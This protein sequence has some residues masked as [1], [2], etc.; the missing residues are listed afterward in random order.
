MRNVLLTV[1]LVCIPAVASAQWSSFNGF[2]PGMSKAAAKAAGYVNCRQSDGRIASSDSIVCDIPA[3]KRSLN[4]LTAE[5]ATLEFASH[6]T[7]TVK[8]VHVTLQ[9]KIE[10][11]RGQL[12]QAYG[13]PADDGPYYLWHRNGA[14]SIELFKRQ[15]TSTAYVTFRYD[16]SMGEAR[17]KRVRDEAKKKATLKSF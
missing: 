6:N 8:A 13:T 10:A 16:K 12:A 9:A 14:E 11:V 7:T 5:A 4:S 17:A 1:M 2:Y 15:R 3:N